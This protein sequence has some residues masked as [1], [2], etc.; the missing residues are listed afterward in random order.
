[1]EL[2]IENQKQNYLLKVVFVVLVVIG[3]NFYLTKNLINL[4][5][6]RRDE[7]YGI[8][9]QIFLNERDYYEIK[10]AEQ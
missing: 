3:G 9:Y 10:I 6:L 2:L 8:S 1:M 5:S 4:N 7:K